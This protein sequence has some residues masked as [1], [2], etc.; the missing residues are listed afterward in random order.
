MGVFDK[1]I[2]RKP[3]AAANTGTAAESPPCPHTTLAP[4]WDSAADMGH[5]DKIAGYDCDSCKQHFTAGQGRDLRR[6]EAARLKH[7]LEA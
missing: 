4:R 6:T 5:E 2:G 7:T 3:A 1:L